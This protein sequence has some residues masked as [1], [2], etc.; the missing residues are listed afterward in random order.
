MIWRIEKRDLLGWTLFRAI[1]H[2]AT[3]EALKAQG[4]T[5]NFIDCWL[6]YFQKNYQEILRMYH[7]AMIELFKQIPSIKSR[8]HSQDKKHQLLIIYIGGSW[9]AKKRV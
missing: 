5:L 3:T 8:A 7:D 4:P 9:Y 1:P 6:K 2:N